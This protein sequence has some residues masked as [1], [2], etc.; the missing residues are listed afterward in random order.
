MTPHEASSSPN[1]P[2][3]M[4][5]PVVWCGGGAVRILGV[6]SVYRINTPPAEDDDQEDARWRISCTPRGKPPL[7]R[8]VHPTLV[9]KVPIRDAPDHRKDTEVAALEHWQVNITSLR[10]LIRPDDLHRLYAGTPLEAGAS[11]ID[12]LSYWTDVDLSHLTT[13]VRPPALPKRTTTPIAIHDDP[14]SVRTM[15]SCSLPVK[16]PPGQSVRDFI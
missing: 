11:V 16:P 4:F 14:S 5:S 12:A 9:R 1:G 8:S 6:A 15:L 10:G 7:E 13:P 2:T 3:Y